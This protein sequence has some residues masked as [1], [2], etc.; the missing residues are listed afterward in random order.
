MEP[1][2]LWKRYLLTNSEFLW[3]TLGL[4]VRKRLGLE[5]ARRAGG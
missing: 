2:K 1:R 5:S 3:L 4:V